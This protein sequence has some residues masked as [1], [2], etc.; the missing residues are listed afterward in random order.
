M[1]YLMKQEI[2]ARASN[3]S[4][5]YVLYGKP[6][7]RLS[8]W[9]R[10]KRSKNSAL[11]PLSFVI[12]K[13]E[14]LGIIGRN[15]SG[16]STLLQILAGII[17]PTTGTIDVKGSVGALLELGSGFNPEF[18]GVENVRLN[19]AITGR[20]QRL[21]DE[22][23]QE[24]IE[25]SGIGQAAYNPVK[26]YSSGMLVRLAFAVHA[27]IQHD[28]LIIDEA[29]AVGDEAFQKKCYN[30]LR[31]LK[32]EGVS[33]ILVTHSCQA[34]VQ[35]CDRV[36]LLDNGNIRWTGRPDVTTLLYQKL[37]NS[38]ESKWSKKY[39]DLGRQ[40]TTSKN[41]KQLETEIPAEELSANIGSSSKRTQVNINT[42]EYWLDHNLVSESA[43]VY[44]SN[45]MT[46][47]QVRITL[48]DGTEAN[49]LPAG[50][51]FVIELSAI[52]DVDQS[53]LRYTS[54]LSAINGVRI[55][56]QAFPGIHEYDPTQL[57]AGTI[58]TIRFGYRGSLLPG[59]YFIGCGI[60]SRNCDDFIHRV[61]DYCCLRVTESSG[62]YS[63]GVC[64]LS[65]SKPIA[66]L[67]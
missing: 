40:L 60:L 15:G 37:L 62:R 4:K 53:Y 57:T 20:K 63:F 19:S 25:F 38:G 1:F 12:R 56:G 65:E 27:M 16:K 17:K 59:L 31:E 29:L 21:S 51:D 18:T 32:D 14:T 30:R 23:I 13:G 5:E 46:I 3:I 45:G 54:H 8:S 2:V 66:Y 44:P 52:V 9:S 6:I 55:S 34:V 35:H 22:D 64:D 39:V 36:M 48:P 7:E 28:L 41:N 43:C 58:A 10:K 49:T 33:I 24:I 67:T 50:Q 42:T 61:V 11:N 26:T 47:S